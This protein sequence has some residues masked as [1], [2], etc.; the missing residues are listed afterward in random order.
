MDYL[1][2][3]GIFKLFTCVMYT[4]KKKSCFFPPSRIATIVWFDY[5]STTSGHLKFA[6]NL[7]H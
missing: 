1:K 5:I 4:H 7:L 2:H 6:S 3:F